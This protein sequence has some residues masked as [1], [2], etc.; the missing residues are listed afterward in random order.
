MLVPSEARRCRH[1]IWGTRGQSQ[2]SLVFRASVTMVG[3]VQGGPVDFSSMASFP[4]FTDSRHTFS[5]FLPFAGG[6]RPRGPT[7]KP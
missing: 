2:G 6:Y 5:T 1:R 4:R 3:W 7:K